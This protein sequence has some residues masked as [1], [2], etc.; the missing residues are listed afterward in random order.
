MTGGT[1]IGSELTTEALKILMGIFSVFFLYN[2]INLPST[3]HTKQH[4][5]TQYSSLKSYFLASGIN[6]NISFKMRLYIQYI[7]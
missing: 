2:R 7:Y 6:I 1:P 5:P 4:R 3:E